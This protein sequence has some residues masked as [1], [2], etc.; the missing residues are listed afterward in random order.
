MDNIY[1]AALAL[2]RN[3]TDAEDLAQET[4]LRAYTGFD[5]YQ[6][7]TNI[8]AWLYRILSNTFVSMYRKD[9]RDLQSIGRPLPEDW[10]LK[11]ETDAYE[12]GPPKAV[13]SSAESEALHRMA[14]DEAYGLLLR[15]PESQRVAVYLADVLGFSYSEISQIAEVPEGTVMSRLHR[16]RRK[17]RDLAERHSTSFGVEQLDATPSSGSVAGREGS[18]K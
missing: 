10:M 8:Q 9:S 14:L 4:F 1:G 13:S 7:G 16:G 17:L 12:D 11:G 3:P 2:T 5:K 15:L 6:A 18:G